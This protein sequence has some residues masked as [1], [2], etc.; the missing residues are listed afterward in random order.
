MVS[1]TPHFMLASVSC[2]PAL[3][4]TTQPVSVRLLHELALGIHLMPP[5][6]LIAA[7]TLGGTAEIDRALLRATAGGGVDLS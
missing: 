1:C 5:H 3:G 7:K 2:R 6:D 4:D